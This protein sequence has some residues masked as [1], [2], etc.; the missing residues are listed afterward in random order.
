MIPRVV[1]STFASLAAVGAI[2]QLL[3]Q[4]EN[5]SPAPPIADAPEAIEQQQPAFY[6]RAAVDRDDRTYHED[7]TPSLRVLAEV[8]AYLYVLYKQADGKVYQVFPNKSQTEN[9]VKAKQAVTIGEGNDLFRWVVGA[10]YGKE[11]IKVIAS[12]EPIAE[13]SKPGLQRDDFNLVSK[14]EIKGVAVELEQAKPAVWSESILEIKTVAGPRPRP[15]PVTRRV[16]VFF[17]VAKYEFSD[18]HVESSP[19]PKDPNKPLNLKGCANDAREMAKLLKESGGLQEAQVLVNEQ[20]TRKNLELAITQWLPSVTGPGDTAFIF[21]S[22]HGGQIADDNGDEADKLDEYL[23]PYDYVTGSALVTLLRRAREGK[24]DDGLKPRVAALLR[25][26]QR[27]PSD[28][29]IRQLLTRSTGISD[30]L[31]GHW[32]QRLDGRQVV[33]IVD[34]CHSG[35]FATQEKGEAKADDSM[36]EDSFDFLDGEIGRLKDIG[37]R[38]SVLFAACHAAE[39][40]QDRAVGDELGVMT[41]ALLKT[42]RSAKAGLEIRPAHRDTCARVDQYFQEINAQLAA[43]GT[44]RRFKPFQPY[45]V[46]H[47][48][49]PVY[50]KP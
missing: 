30:D 24:L 6:V 37:Q 35:G 34:A 47:C 16:G 17:G 13:L 23:L 33:V 18:A 3:A 29:Q 5:A 21:F 19:D 50:L 43:A 10:P 14:D 12:K 45:L 8:D 41:D 20:A 11:W 32:I 46:N 36:D 40:S 22:G 15:K 1:F 4:T 2:A 28:E 49:R 7:D 44:S 25:L 38:E 42:I 27:A 31:F 39:L 9:R 26:V 48:S